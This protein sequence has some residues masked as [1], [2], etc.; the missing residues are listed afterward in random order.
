MNDKTELQNISINFELLFILKL[1]NYYQN[2]YIYNNHLNN[3]FRKI[4]HVQQAAPTQ[5]G[6]LG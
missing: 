3:N 4:I 1:S 2:E 6:P 5:N